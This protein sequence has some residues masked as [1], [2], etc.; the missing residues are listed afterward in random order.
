MTH[1]NDE[2]WGQG[3]QASFKVFHQLLLQFHPNFNIKALEALITLE[4]VR[5]AIAKVGEEV[6]ATQ[7]EATIKEAMEADIGEATDV[8]AM[9]V[10]LKEL[11]VV[12]V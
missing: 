12:E 7:K 10:A 11:E 2:A 1:A 5:I 8:E 6:I 9:G 3:V 4:V